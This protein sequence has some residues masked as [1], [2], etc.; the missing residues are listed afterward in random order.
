MIGLVKTTKG[1][2]GIELRDVPR[3]HAGPGHVLIKPEAVGVCGSDIERYVGRLIDYEPPVILGHEFCGTIAELGDDTTR[4]ARGDRVVC[5]THA[6][7]CGHCYFCMTG[8]HALCSERKGFGFGVDGAFAEYVAA[9]PEI[10][11]LMPPQLSFEECAVTE[12][13]CVAIHAVS[14]RLRVRPGDAIAIFGMGPVGLLALQTARLY[15][16]SKIVALDLSENIRL[17]LARDMGASH[18]VA[19]Q[20]RDAV[21]EIF[22]HVGMEG[23]DICIDASGSN[24][25]LM[26]ALKVTKKSGQILVIGQH[27][28]PEEITVGEIV[29]KQLSL[30]GSYSHTWTTW[31]TALKLLSERKISTKAVITH[32]YPLAEWKQAF[33]TLLNLQGAKAVLR[34]PRD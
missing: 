30:I 18:T 4:F 11:H 29:M 33:D 23:V 26:C 17:K 16:A 34:I 8:Q 10:V 27:P 15:G 14:D 12:P 19:S 5:E 13:L 32:T 3:P 9:R 25:A 24:A 22:D 2:G 20:E 7:F 28:K 31:E 21:T 1:K 6:V